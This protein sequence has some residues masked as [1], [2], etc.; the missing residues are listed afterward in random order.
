MNDTLVKRLLGRAEVRYWRI[1]L[2]IL[3][4]L[5]TFFTFRTFNSTSRAEFYAA[6]PKSMS[7]NLSN[8]FFGAFDSAGTSTLDKIPGSYW[9]PAIFVKLFGFNNFSLIAPN[10]IASIATVI[11]I[12][13]TV[14]KYYGPMAGMIAGAITVSTPIFI[15]VARSNQAE[16]F[17]T[18]ILAIVA[19]RMMLALEDKSRRS[20]IIVGAFIALAFQTYMLEAWAVWPAVIVAWLFVEKKFLAK[21]V[22]LVIAGTVS[23]LLSI[24]WIA[25]V[26]L[27]PESHR[28]YIGGTN[29]NNPFEMVF[30][31]NGLGRFTQKATAA[32]TSQDAFRSYTPAFGG[33]AGPFRLFNFQVGGQIG[34]FI[35]TA[36]LAIAILIILKF[37]R[38]IAAFFAGWFIVFTVIFSYV[39]GIHQFYTSVLTISIAFLVALAIESS[40]R[41]GLPAL[42]YI[43]IGTTVA[44]SFF[45]GFR[46]GD[47]FRWAP[48]TQAILFALLLGSIFVKK[49]RIKNLYLPYVL[50]SSLVW[51]PAV[52]AFDTV[53]EANGGNPIAGPSQTGMVT[54]ANGT[55]ALRKAYEKFVAENGLI[56]V[57]TGKTLKYL[58]ANKGSAKFIVAVN[59]ELSSASYVTHTNQA[60]LPVG[61]FDGKDPNPTLSQFIDLVKSGK[62]RFVVSSLAQK[63]ATLETV[64]G[65]KKNSA[66]KDP[67]ISNP[68]AKAIAA[69]QSNLELNKIKRWVGANCQNDTRA[70]VPDSLYDC[71]LIK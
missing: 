23:L 5:S 59:T 2:G 10:A 27:I 61:G 41:E 33:S 30:G 18:L 20:L 65:I 28:P 24:T 13:Q 34:W 56:S 17:F 71:Q 35:P 4:L 15:A 51:T 62:L 60:I 43:V 55:K 57:Q 29:H 54:S 66:E 14:K 39:G 64:V 11:I 46:Y 49:S 16:S 45:L 38:P 37:N 19:N 53:R 50:I 9:I 63:P 12:A 1:S 40:L 22:D 48:I 44:W 67:V 68:T 52:W 47:F 25:I 21:L 70:P 26:Y 8:F 42:V 69:N 31:Y 3:T 36:V 7:L 58:E 6:M 32:I